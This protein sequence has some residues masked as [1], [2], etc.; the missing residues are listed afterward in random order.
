[1]ESIIVNFN[2]E[3]E[4]EEYE[5]KL[6]D[7]TAEIEKY[8][9]SAK[10]TGKFFDVRITQGT[11]CCPDVWI[12]NLERKPGSMGHWGL[13][14]R[15]PGFNSIE[16]AIFDVESFLLYNIN[17]FRGYEVEWEKVVDNPEWRKRFYHPLIILDDKFP[18][19]EESKG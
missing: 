15:I 1:M 11:A 12:W 19:S 9:T 2:W 5:H 13:T 6:P 10:L 3:Y 4:W 16:D 7:E 17:R 14:A 18:D 8:K